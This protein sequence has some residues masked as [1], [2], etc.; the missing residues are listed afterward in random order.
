MSGSRLEQLYRRYGPAIFSRCRR[1]L[2]DDAAAEDAASEVFL[3]IM[4]H[5]DKAPD[6][7]AVMAWIYRISTNYCLNVLRGQRH[8]AVPTEEVPELPSAH[9]E[10]SHIDR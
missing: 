9:P 1:L 2:R 3:R 4:R 5:I 8:Q 7:E 10:L 6:D